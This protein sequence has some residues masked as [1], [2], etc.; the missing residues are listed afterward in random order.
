[1]AD[2]QTTADNV[3]HPAIYKRRKRALEPFVHL[4]QTLGEGRGLT[5]AGVEVVTA[6]Q[7]A[8]AIEAYYAE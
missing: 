2:H 3:P 4:A 1:M 6:D 8:A 7:F 5:V